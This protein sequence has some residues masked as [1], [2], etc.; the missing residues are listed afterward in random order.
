MNYVIPISLLMLTIAVFFALGRRGFV[1]F[2]ATQAVVRVLAALP[3]IVSGVLLH[4]ICV[5]LTASIIPPAFP[6]RS[7]LVVVT[8]LLEIA[9]AAGLFLPKARRAAAFWIAIMMMAIFPANVY[10]AGRA[11]AG[12]Q[13]PGV[14]VRTAM[15]IV[16]IVVVLLAGYGVPVRKMPE[17]I[18]QKDGR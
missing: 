2:G 10:I 17:P 7:L 18:V 15:Q 11:V 16:Y 13:M 6:A 12:I 8:G 5:Q 1:S 4:L 14:A 3:L 9:G